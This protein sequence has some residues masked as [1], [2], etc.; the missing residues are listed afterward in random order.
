M[1]A[2]ICF[3]SC[4]WTRRWVHGVISEVRAGA[5][6]QCL[7]RVGTTPALSDALDPTLSELDGALK[8]LAAHGRSTIDTD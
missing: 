1:R 2:N 5:L 8:K 4:P 6:G 3:T 7:G